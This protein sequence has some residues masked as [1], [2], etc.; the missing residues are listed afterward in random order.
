M[1]RRCSNI[2]SDVLSLQVHKK[3]LAQQIKSSS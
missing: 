2:I 3:R 1:L